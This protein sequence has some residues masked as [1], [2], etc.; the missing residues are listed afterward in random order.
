MIKG[1]FS[2]NKEKKELKEKFIYY[3]FYVFNCYFFLYWY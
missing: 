2:S 1:Q 3:F